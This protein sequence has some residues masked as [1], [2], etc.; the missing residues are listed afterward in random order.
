MNHGFGFKQMK[1]FAIR[2]NILHASE[3]KNSFWDLL[4]GNAAIKNE[5]KANPQLFQSNSVNSKKP[6]Y[7]LSSIKFTETMNTA[8]QLFKVV[9]FK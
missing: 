2:N 8:V 1:S 4:N 3:T 7:K 5:K 9:Y 6:A